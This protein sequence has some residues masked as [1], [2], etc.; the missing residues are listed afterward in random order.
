MSNNALLKRGGRSERNEKQYYGN[1]FKPTIILEI[2]I[3]S[4]FFALKCTG[5]SIA[6]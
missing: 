2:I 5:L 4:H 6:I 3:L 1:K